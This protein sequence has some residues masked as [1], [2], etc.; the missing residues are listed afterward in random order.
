MTRYVGVDVGVGGMLAVAEGVGGRV[1][2]TGVS[3]AGTGEGTI[4]GEGLA[5]GAQAVKQRI[6]KA[7]AMNTRGLHTRGLLRRE[8]HPSQ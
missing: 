8:E 3:E 4:T 6:E 5:E 2:T 7:I 1:V